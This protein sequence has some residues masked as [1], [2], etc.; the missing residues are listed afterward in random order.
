MPYLLALQELEPRPE[1][2]QVLRQE[3]W[4]AR[5]PVWRQVQELRLK[6]LPVLQLLS[7]P[8]LQRLSLF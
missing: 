3:Q 8:S 1:Q 5:Q 6:R 7:Y 4:L 2:Q